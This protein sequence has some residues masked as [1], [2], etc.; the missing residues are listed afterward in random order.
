MAQFREMNIAER[1]A[2]WQRLNTHRVDLFVPLLRK[3]AYSR[4]VVQEAPSSTSK[5]AYV[6]RGAVLWCCYCADWMVFENFTYV[7]S[8]KCI[9]CGISTKDFY[10]RGANK[11]WDVDV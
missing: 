8:D 7:G 10:N 4:K 11:L 2:L 6:H 5:P 3:D 1:H 9:G